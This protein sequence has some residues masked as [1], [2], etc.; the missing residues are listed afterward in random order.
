MTET[1]Y[2]FSQGVF[3]VMESVFYWI[4]NLITSGRLDFFVRNWYWV[5]LFVSVTA[6]VID[7]ALVLLKGYQPNILVVWL[8]KGYHGVRRLIDPGY[9]PFD[10]SAPPPEERLLT[11]GEQAQVGSV[12]TI[13]RPPVLSWQLEAERRRE[14]TRLTLNASSGVEPVTDP[15]PLKGGRNAEAQ[16]EESTKRHKFLSTAPIPGAEPST[17]ETKAITQQRNSA[18]V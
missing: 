3:R 16:P 2:Q 18:D 6:I 13:E 5:A 11:G 17:R 4:Y 1:G 10:K 8:I 14:R 7:Q 15:N 12:S 9:A